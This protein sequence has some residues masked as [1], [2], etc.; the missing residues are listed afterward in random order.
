MPQCHVRYHLLRVTYQMFWSSTVRLSIGS[1]SMSFVCWEVQHASFVF[2]TSTAGHAQ[3]TVMLLRSFI[4]D[5]NGE[6]RVSRLVETEG[7][8]EFYSK[9]R[10]ANNGSVCFLVSNDAIGHGILERGRQCRCEVECTRT[11]I[12]C[13]YSYISMI[14]HFNALPSPIKTGASDNQIYVL[15]TI[16]TWPSASSLILSDSSV[17]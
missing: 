12:A 2:A 4:V 3:S 11:K 7:S 9:G 1:E 15:H 6:G 16:S 8:K 10:D 13:S 5:G 14:C 17:G